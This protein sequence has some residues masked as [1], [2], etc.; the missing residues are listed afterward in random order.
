MHAK[1]TGSVDNCSPV[2]VNASDIRQ[3]HTILAEQAAVY[4]KDPGIQD[5]R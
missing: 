3:L 2:P 4:H 5:M 1:S